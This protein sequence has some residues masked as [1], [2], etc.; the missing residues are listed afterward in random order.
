MEHEFQEEEAAAQAE[1]ESA[2]EEIKNKASEEYNV[3]RFTLDGLIEELE[4]HF[5]AAHANYTSSTEQRTADF[6]ALTLKDQ[7]S[8]KTIET[9]AERRPALPL[10]PTTPG[11]NAPPTVCSDE[12]ITTPLLGAAASTAARSDEPVEGPA[13]SQR[14]GVRGPPSR[15][16]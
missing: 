2:R 13:R 6:K 11:S 3:L 14:P 12:R 1:F 4:R 16:P 5:D 8:A 7:Q 9:Q 10:C 15:S